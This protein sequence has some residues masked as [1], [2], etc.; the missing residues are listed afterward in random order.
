MHEATL[1]ASRVL[2][3]ALSELSQKTFT[4]RKDP[5]RPASLSQSW[6]WTVLVAGSLEE[7]REERWPPLGPPLSA[8]ARLGP[9]RSAQ[10][11]FCPTDGSDSGRRGVGG[12]VLPGAT[13]RVCGPELSQLFRFVCAPSLRN[14]ACREFLTDSPERREICYGVEGG[15]EGM[16][17]SLALKSPEGLSCLESDGSNTWRLLFVVLCSRGGG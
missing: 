6:L 1:A 5:Q 2:R 12:R 16:C 3:V 14:T 17:V 11:G 8:S 15:S 10:A 13:A 9:E 7:G 4:K